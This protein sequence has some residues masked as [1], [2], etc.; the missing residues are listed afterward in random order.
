VGIAHR[1]KAVVQGAFTE[2]MVF[3]TARAIDNAASK[4]DPGDVILIELQAELHKDQE[5]F[6]AMQF[7]SE[8]FTAIRAAVNKGIVV[9]EAAGNG[10]QDFGAAKYKETGLQ[11]D[12][13]AIV[14][15]AGVPPTNRVD[16]NGSG[17]TFPSYASLGAPRS[18][19]CFSNYGQ[20]VNLQGWG[21][22]VTSTGYGDAGGATVNS[23]YTLRFNGTSSASPIVTAAVACLQGRA[24]RVRGRALTPAEVRKTLMDTGTPQVANPGAPVSQNHIGPQPDLVAALKKL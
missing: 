22:H 4:L 8:V 18:R 9:V 21:W 6:V 13:G 3:N 10:G 5:D 2:E 20:I 1:A 24:R 11:K 12:S 14:V 16:F 7:F 23:Q 17:S 15:G 19:I